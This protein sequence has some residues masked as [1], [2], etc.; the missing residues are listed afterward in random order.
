MALLADYPYLTLAQMAFML[1]MAV[2]A[3]KR[4][5]DSFWLWVTLQHRCLLA[6]HLLDNGQNDEARTLLERC[7]QDYRFAPGPSRRLNRTWL[8]LARRLHRRTMAR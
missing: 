6:E 4:P 1:W 8:R 2:D 5:A 3:Y 7:L